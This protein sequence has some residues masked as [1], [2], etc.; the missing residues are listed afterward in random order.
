MSPRFSCRLKF[1]KSLSTDCARVIP[2]PTIAITTTVRA[3]RALSHTLNAIL[4]EID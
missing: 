4:L 2:A 3:G 1:A